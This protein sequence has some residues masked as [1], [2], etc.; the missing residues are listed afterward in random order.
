MLQ[1]IHHRVKNNMQ[2]VSSLLNLYSSNIQDKEIR[3]M[4]QECRSRSRSMSLLHDRLYQS[5]DLAN[6]DFSPYLNTLV[7]DLFRMHQV[8]PSGIRLETELGHLELDINRAIPC[9]LI[10]NE[11]VSNS[12][13]HAFP[14]QR[15]GTIRIRMETKDRGG[16]RLIV[17]D[18]GIGLPVHMDF[19]RTDSLGMRLLNDLVRQIDGTIHLESGEGTSFQI[20][21]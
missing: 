14:D 3:L 19:R 18:N 13:K 5:E 21:F 4:F 6:I 15:G 20:D 16:I 11:L 8:D 10:I 12:L 17:S 2:V 7:A 1:E 9:G